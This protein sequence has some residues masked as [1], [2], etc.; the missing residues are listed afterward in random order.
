MEKVKI[1]K[2]TDQPN[3]PEI[4]EEEYE[5]IQQEVSKNPQK[6]RIEEMRERDIKMDKPREPQAKWQ[7][8]KSKNINHN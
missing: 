2:M 1:F 6:Y 8:P 4:S 7:K 3:A 5:N